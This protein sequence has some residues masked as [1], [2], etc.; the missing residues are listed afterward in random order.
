MTARQFDLAV[1]RARA[2][3]LMVSRARRV[4]VDGE[5]AK[6]VAKADG[7]TVATVYKAVRQVSAGHRTKAGYW[8]GTSPMGG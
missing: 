6:A 8:P 2:S 1:E 5:T 3:E 4:L 7:V